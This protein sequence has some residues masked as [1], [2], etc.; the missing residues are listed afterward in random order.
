MAKAIDNFIDSGAF[1]GDLFLLGIN[2]AVKRTKIIYANLTKRD[3][4]INQ[5][6]DD[7]LFEYCVLGKKKY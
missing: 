4:E 6:V 1:I 7:G 2:R 3:Y 5:D